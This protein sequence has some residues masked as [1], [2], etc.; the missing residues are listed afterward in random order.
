MR[1]A[2]SIFVAGLFVLLSIVARAEPPDSLMSDTIAVTERILYRGS[3]NGDCVIDTVFGLRSA[4]GGFV[5][6]KISWGG[7]DTLHYIP[8]P[9]E[10]PPKF[11]RYRATKFEYSGLDSLGGSVAFVNLDGDSLN[12]VLL[13]LWWRTGASTARHDTARVLGIFS[14]RRFDTVS[15]VLPAL[16]PGL[17]LSPFVAMQFMVGGALSQPAVR[18]V[19]EITSY[20]LEQVQ[21][22]GPPP[23]P[24]HETADVPMS[25][26]LSI[27][28]NPT[29][30]SASVTSRTV[31]P[32]SYELVVLDIT[33][34]VRY[35]ESIS[36]SESRSLA[37]T[38]D[39]H[40]LPSGYYLVRLI[41]AGMPELSYPVIISR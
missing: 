3:L 12:D 10:F 1:H 13:T 39:L 9:G 35:R 27:Y 15:T 7:G 11:P 33:G 17:Q 8:C 40:L 34:A 25:A 19:S 6:T 41:N 28:P 23:P 5:P 31:P 37:G 24:R 29:A 38:I 22:P 20:M 21:R 18:D 26:D 2:K 32:G 4:F 36:V 16:L 30:W 14:Q